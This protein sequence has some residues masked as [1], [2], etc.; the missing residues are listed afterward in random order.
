MRKY[1]LMAFIQRMASPGSPEKSAG[2]TALSSGVVV[3][4]GV[5]NGVEGMTGSLGGKARCQ[6][7]KRHAHIRCIVS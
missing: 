6:L 1:A 3:D 7:V 5:V 4:M 2:R